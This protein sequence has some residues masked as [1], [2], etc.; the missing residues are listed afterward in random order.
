MEVDSMGEV[1]NNFET[2]YFIGK[3]IYV[4]S[5]AKWIE[6]YCPTTFEK[7]TYK[8]TLANDNDESTRLSYGGRIVFADVHSLHVLD[9]RPIGHSLQL[10]NPRRQEILVQSLN[11]NI[12][13]RPNHP[14]KLYDDDDFNS[15]D[16][17]KIGDNGENVEL[18]S[19]TL[20]HMRNSNN[21]DENSYAAAYIIPEYQW[22]EGRGFN[23]TNAPF[24]LYLPGVPPNYEAHRAEIISNKES[25]TLGLDDFWIGY[26]LVSYQADSLSDAD[27]YGGFYGIS[28]TKNNAISENQDF[29]TPYFG[30]PAGGIG[31]I[32][33]IETM[34]DGNLKQPPPPY[35]DPLYR[36]YTLAKTRTAPHE[37]GHQFGLNHNNYDPNGGILSYTGDLHFSP[38]HIN[39]LRWRVILSKAINLVSYAAS[40]RRT[41]GRKF[42]TPDYRACLRQKPNLLPC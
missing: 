6:V 11:G 28:P 12:Y 14:F 1:A 39:M 7:N 23:N 42:E 17:Q 18:L 29:Y 20:S 40:P 24:K 37:V 27:F 34:R 10:Q 38:N 41:S 2:G 19:D 22:A 5:Q 35:P 25:F 8:Q 3:G 9:S 32:I 4:G 13:L 31:A 36:D 21:P 33:F 30:M 26:L 15:D 16:L